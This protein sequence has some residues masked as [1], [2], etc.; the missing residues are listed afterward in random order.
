MAGISADVPD[1]R[2]GPC[3][4]LIKIMTDPEVMKRVSVVD[5]SLQYLMFPRIS[6]YDDME[7]ESPMYASFRKIVENEKNKLFRTYSSFME[8]LDDR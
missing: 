6:F 7:K 4:E 1:D 5:G 3:M 8:E 2:I